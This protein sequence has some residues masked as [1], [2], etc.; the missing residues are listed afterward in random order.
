M[1]VLKVLCQ[2]LVDKRLALGALLGE[3]FADLNSIQ[4]GKILFTTHA[5]HKIF[6][7]LSTDSIDSIDATFPVR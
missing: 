5:L 7:P 4:Y 6:E 1:I 2:Y 3:R